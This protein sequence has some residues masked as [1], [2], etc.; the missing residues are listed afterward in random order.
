MVTAPEVS[1]ALR[2][3]TRLGA[4]VDVALAHRLD[5]RPMDNVALGHVMTADPPLGPAELAT[6][7]GISSGSGTELV[8]RLEGAGHLQRRRDPHDRRRVELH[9]SGPAVQSVLRELA[10]LFAGLD[11]LADEFST[12]EQETIIRYLRGAGA[13]MRQ[14]AGDEPAPA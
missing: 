4:E 9:A 8:D 14:F 5:L 11:Q 10:P 6:R 2:E 7:L 12:T 3:V 13:R 1:W